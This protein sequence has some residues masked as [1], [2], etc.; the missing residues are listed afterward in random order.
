MALAD[1]DLCVGDRVAR[2]E[3]VGRITRIWH[4][5]HNRKLSA[6]PTCLYDVTWEDNDATTIG[7]LAVALKRIPE[8]E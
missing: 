3:R 5:A 1:R 7:H 2:G 6:T 8:D 4:T